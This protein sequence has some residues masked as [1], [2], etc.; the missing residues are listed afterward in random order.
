MSDF[1]NWRE[2]PEP[3]PRYVCLGLAAREAITKATTKDR[4]FA[5]EYWVLAAY[6]SAKLAAHAAFRV[7]PE[8]RG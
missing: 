6:N 5:H 4:R 8:L 3:L 2:R 7:H 1:P